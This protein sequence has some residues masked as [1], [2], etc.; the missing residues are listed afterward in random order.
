M[1]PFRIV[2]VSDAYRRFLNADILY[3]CDGA[4]WDAH[5]GAT[6]FA[7]E[8]W[9]SHRGDEKHASDNKLDVAA[10]YGLN[11]VEGAHEAGFSSNPAVIHYGC[12]SGF[13]AVN[14]AL[15]KGATRIVLVGFDMRT[16]DGKAHF[17]GDHPEGLRNNTDFRNFIT[18]FRQAGAPVPI[19]NATPGSALDC[20]PM[21]RLEDALADDSVHRDRAEPYARTG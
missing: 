14:I 13:Q 3:S 16:V 11:L 7:G 6:E 9:S 12:N 20:Y 4:W 8:R 17:F 18:A 15:L 21:I 2:C 1:G 19:V 10:R 5:K